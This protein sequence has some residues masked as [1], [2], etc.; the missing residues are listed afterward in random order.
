[1]C[2]S[3]KVKQSLRD[4]E[5]QFGAR[6][7]YRQILDLFFRRLNE[8]SAKIQISRAFEDNFI[9]PRNDDERHIKALIDQHRAKLE[10]DLMQEM[11]AQLKRKADAERALQTKVTKKAENDARIGGKKAEQIKAR[12]DDLKRT[13][14][15]ARDSRIFPMQY[16]PIIIREDGDSKI[17]LARYHCRGQG[18]PASIDTERDGLYNARRDNLEKYWRSEFSKTHAVCVIDAFFE[19]VERDG[20]N[21]VLQFEPNPPKEM[22]VACLY[23][24]WSGPGALDLLSFAA[25]TDE[26]PAEV[27]AAGHDRCVVN[28]R[29]AHVDAWLAPQ[30][31][32]S[33]ALQDILADVERPIYAHQV[34]EAA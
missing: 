23:A 30:G 2:Y 32:D 25:I 19:N 3:A 34:A 13:T 31:R 16:A 17:V 20:K 14:P 12:L 29:S 22:I 1:M 10:T 15:E 4:L 6:P 24:R 11:F 21:V 18:K 5:R 28:L 8:P 27:A 7:D 33:D 26:P 9:E